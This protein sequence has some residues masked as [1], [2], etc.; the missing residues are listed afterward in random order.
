MKAMNLVQCAQGKRTVSVYLNRGKV[1]KQPRLMFVHLKE[2]NI[3]SKNTK[4]N[5]RYDLQNFAN[6]VL[7][8]LNSCK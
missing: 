8:G 5:Y 4:Q 3:D 7:R 6:Y 2:L 1:K